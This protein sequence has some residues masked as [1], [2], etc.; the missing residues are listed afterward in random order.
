V[1]ARVLSP[2]GKDDEYAALGR[3]DVQ[4]ELAARLVCRELGATPF[5]LTSSIQEGANQNPKP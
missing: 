5:A 3:M 2:T 4:D 1:W